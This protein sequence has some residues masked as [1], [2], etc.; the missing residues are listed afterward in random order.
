MDIIEKYK[1]AVVQIS[2]SSGSSGTGFYLADE[3]LIVT[4]EHVVRNFNE[5]VVSGVQFDK[6]LAT[7]Y[8]ADAYFDMAFMQPPGQVQLEHIQ[9]SNHESI[10]EGERVTAIGHPYG[11]KYTATQGII[12]KA[13]R[14]FNDVEYIQIDAAINPGNSGGPLVDE[15]GE[16]IGI[17]SSRIQEGDNLGFALPAH[18]I[19][20]ALN[21]YRPHYGKAA[22]RCS[23]CS[24]FLIKEMLDGTYCPN[25]GSVVVISDITQIKEPEVTGTAKDIEALLQQCGVQIK[26]ARKQPGAWEFKHGNRDI[27]IR[28]SYNSN[29]GWIVADAFMG[30]LPKLGI[31]KLYEFLLKTN[32]ELKQHLFCVQQ[33]N[34][35]LSF[36]IYD[37]YFDMYQASVQFQDFFKYTDQYDDTLH[38]DFALLPLSE[39]V[40]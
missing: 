16:V 25:C 36:M 30:R 12:S 32:F 29:E 7:V 35:I 38:T 9:L 37:K 13:R 39:E 26:L 20:Q 6:Q 40:L 31:D 23:N 21:E 17:N 18:Y 24:T 22:T 4:N 28:V 33:Q 11:L 1:N 14:L 3:N 10:R 27:K 15:R 2:T 19:K 34:I 5:V 8:Y